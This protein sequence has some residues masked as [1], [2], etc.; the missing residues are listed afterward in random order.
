MSALC[1]S[2]RRLDQAQLR[3][4]AASP[5][6]RSLVHV[7]AAGT[8]EK[9]G[10]SPE[11]PAPADPEGWYDVC[12]PAR[13]HAS[14]SLLSVLSY[15][16]NGLGK[17]TKE[18]KWKVIASLVNDYDVTCLQ[19][20]FGG[21]QDAA[22]MADHVRRGLQS[23]GLDTSRTEIVCNEKKSTYW[24]RGQGLVNIINLSGGGA[25]P[26][27]PGMFPME[28]ASGAPVAPDDLADRDKP[29]LLFTLLPLEPVPV[30]LINVY[31]P[32]RAKTI[33]RHVL[34]RIRRLIHQGQQAPLPRR[35][36]A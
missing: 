7:C 29:Q 20:C 9:A 33:P 4:S 27:K 13:Y 28:A 12:E 11:Q 34:E 16:V 36:S 23:V 19:E 18:D 5:K 25:A 8:S 26:A 24:T 32:P 1:A 21:A 31:L 15:N 30:L 22:E 10:P 14:L 2:G 35:S 6:G 3:A 17:A